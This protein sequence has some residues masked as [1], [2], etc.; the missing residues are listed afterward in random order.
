MKTQGT[1]NRGQLWKNNVCAHV[2]A[3]VCV[4]VCV[5]SPPPVSVFSCTHDFS[6]FQIKKRKNIALVLNV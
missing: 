3:C 5:C 4:C 1:E 6:Q 2:C